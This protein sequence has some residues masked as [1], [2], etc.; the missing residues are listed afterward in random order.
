MNQAFF[1]YERQ[2]EVERVNEPVW[3]ITQTS[4]SSTA[5]NSGQ[6]GEGWNKRKQQKKA[7]SH[8]AKQLKLCLNK[9]NLQT[10]K[11]IDDDDDSRRQVITT[12]LQMSSFTE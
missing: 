5:C 7:D 11:V 1:Q 8:R 4:Q 9:Q 2:C 12:S 6:S 10:A 3:N